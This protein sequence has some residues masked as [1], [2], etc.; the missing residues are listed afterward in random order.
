MSSIYDT[1]LKN[2]YDMT[3]W[4]IHF[5]RNTEWGD[6]KSNLVSII[7]QGVIKPNWAIRKGLATVYGREPAVCFTEQPL[8]AFHHYVHSKND[9]SKVSGYA[10]LIHKNDLFASGGLP[11]IY[12]AENISCFQEGD[13]GFI[14]GWRIIK[15]EHIPY[16]EQYRFVN[17]NPNRDGYPIDW[18]F[19]REW[20]WSAKNDVN[21]M[22]GYL[23]SGKVTF[24]SNKK[25]SHGR[26]HILV[27][28]EIDIQW[29][30][31]NVSNIDYEDKTNIYRNMW[32][33]NLRSKT[34]VLSLESIIN[35]LNNGNHLFGKADTIFA[36]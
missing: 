7:N 12:G 19:E 22:G 6:A 9:A 3:D 28:K 30:K 23:L 13:V 32:L 34:K 18:T 21:Q 24:S 31:S 27:E 16:D 2:C 25:Y 35:N 5:T 8:W 10:I 15:P 11:V 29:L 36:T 17:Y 20:R 14:P 1:L 33:N 26:T 4:M